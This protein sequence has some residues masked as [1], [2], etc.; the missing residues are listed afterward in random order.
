M[1]EKQIESFTNSII[2]L[3]KKIKGVSVIITDRDK[4][5]FEYY[6]GV[7]DGKGT[8]N[9]NK[10]MMMI[11]SNTKL[12]TTIAIMQFIEQGKLSLED[13]IQT[14]LPEVKIPARFTYDAITIK[15]LLMHRSGIS[16]DDFSCEL[17]PT[18]TLKDIIPTVNN[19]YM[20]SVPGTMYAYSNLGFG[21]L[22]L[23][24]EKL[25][26]TTY[27]DYIYENVTKPLG[28]DMKILPT[29]EGR[30][31]Y[32]NVISQSFN[33]KGEVVID[34][35][36]AILSA[37]SNTYATADD[38]AKL[39]RLF[40]NPEK[41]SVLKQETLEKVLTMIDGP[42]Y[43]D[44]E[45][46]HG[47]G[48]MF[49]CKNYESEAIGEIIGHG[50]AT[51]YHYSTFQFTSKLGIGIA[52]MTNTEKGASKA[53]KI[54]NKLFADYIKLLGIEISM[55]DKTCPQT[56][57]DLKKYENTFVASGMLADFKYTKRSRLVAKIGFVKFYMTLRQ[58]DYFDLHPIGI[59]KLKMF[60]KMLKNIKVKIK[61]LHGEIVVYI[62]SY[63]EFY[64]TVNLIAVLYKKQKDVFRYEYLV[65]EYELTEATKQCSVF[66]TKGS[67]K[68]KENKLL[69]VSKSDGSKSTFYLE[70]ID[71]NTL[72][73][74]GIGRGTRE[75][76]IFT[77]D[78][79][80]IIGTFLGAQFKKV[81]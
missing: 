75:T 19:S 80:E 24:I 51:I 8:K 18:K 27:I 54:T 55:L 34:P 33:K 15:Q 28:M 42:F 74:Q 5:V 13:D 76:V 69:F 47:L 7:I 25:S 38:L 52:V 16:G 41:Q 23:L 39:L 37:G 14:H 65:G 62:K 61:E 59:S 72:L 63:H 21:L 66:F 58:D 9:D 26:N 71:D 48:L 60:S 3:S 1:T 22:G 31:K 36:S 4:T 35:L 11:G 78:N 64:S 81:S 70:G 6:H 44:K 12:L 29:K 20:V 77:K 30:E 32:K 40:M 56:E 73:I 79:N 2:K 53:N 17:D 68:I 49:N 50:G 46:R 43:E 57:V 67:F 10:K 45:E